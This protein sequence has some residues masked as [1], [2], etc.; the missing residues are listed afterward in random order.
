MVSILIQQAN[1]ALLIPNQAVITQGRQTVVTVSQ[2]GTSEVR[3]IKTGISNGQFTEVTDGLAEGEQVII[4]KAAA[5][6]PKAGQGTQQP[7][8]NLVR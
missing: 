8:G 4:P 3:P 7:R 6:T 1:N 5:T 2:N